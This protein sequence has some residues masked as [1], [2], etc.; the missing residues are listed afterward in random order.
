MAAKVTCSHLFS[1]VYAA[2]SHEAERK[3]G[4]DEFEGSNSA[5]SGP[6]VESESGDDLPIS[7]PVLL[8]QEY[9]KPG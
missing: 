9:G 6:A 4:T 8:R 2:L 5:S 3:P 1:C 7:Q